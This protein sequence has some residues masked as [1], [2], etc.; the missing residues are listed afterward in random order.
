MGNSAAK[1][2]QDR[3]LSNGL[4][5]SNDEK[6]IIPNYV[7]SHTMRITASAAFNH[8][9]YCNAD[10]GELIFSSMYK[11]KQG[12]V[13]DAQGNVLAAFKMQKGMV[14]DLI[15]VYRSEPAFKGQ[16][17][18]T[19]IEATSASGQ[20]LIMYKFAILE[21]KHGLNKS[22]NT[23][24]LIQED[25][26]TTPLYVGKR[27]SKL[28]YLVAIERPD[29]EAVAKAAHGKWSLKGPSLMCDAAPGVDM[30]AVIFVAT[31]LDD[32]AGAA[33]ATGGLA[34]AGVI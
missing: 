23:Y 3:P 34:G 20:R 31:C 17:Q 19:D 18:S 25:E 7:T 9:K 33:G 22:E 13:M 11:N 6:A 5:S 4:L 29:G 16:P 21:T 1:A 28:K 14:I 26:K 24:S 2:L 30:V 27:I 8:S 12:T 15:T 32:H 10:T